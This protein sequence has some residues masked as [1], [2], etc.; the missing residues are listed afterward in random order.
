MPYKADKQITALRL[1]EAEESAEKKA[2]KARSRKYGIGIKPGGNMTKPA[3][4][5]DVSENLFADPVNFRY[6]LSPAMRAINAITRFN[7]TANKAKGGYSDAEWAIMGRRIAKANK[8]KIFKDGQVVDREKEAL[9]GSK[10]SLD[11]FVGKIRDAFEAKFARLP[12]GD[13]RPGCWV[14]DT[15]EDHVVAKMDE[16]FYLIPFEI[17]G[18]E[19]IF[20]GVED[21]T[22][23]IPEKTYVPVTEALRILASKKKK[24]EP[25]G[26]EWEVIIIGPES[27]SD[28]VT[29]GKETYV[30]SKNGR[31]YKASALEAS[32][33]LWDGI[34]V[35]DNHLTDDEM[36]AR[37]GMRSVVH[38][39]V[40]VIV[41][42]AWDA[43]K[44]AVT[45]VLKIVDDNLRAKLLNAEKASV[46]D[47]IG[48][49][50][51]ALGEGI[52]ETI[53]GSTTPVIE[54]ISKALS[55]DVVADPAA[56]GRLSR[57]I[58]GMTG[59]SLP[60]GPRNL[61]SQEVEMDPEEL[62]KLIGDA[63]SASM[64]GFNDR[65]AAIEARL[66]SA[67]DDDPDDDS[68]DDD[69]GSSND[70]QTGDQLPEPVAKAIAAAEARAAALEE[71]MRINECAH[72]L[73]VKLGESGLPESY[74]EIIAEQFRGKVFETADLETA[75]TKHRE[76]L[77]KLSE[78]GKIVLPDGARI[79][80]GSLTELDRIELALLRL[81]AGPTRFTELINKEK[82]EYHGIESIKHFIESEKP[83]L[84]YERRLSEWYYRFTEDYDGLGQ[85]R[86]KRLLEAQVTSSSLSSIV[87]NVV[88]L[89]LAADY[90]VREQW[91][92]PIVRQED[93]D[94]LDQATLVRVFGISTLTA[95]SEGDAYVESAWADE[96]E[97]ASYVKRGNYIGV[98]L[99]T[100]LLDKLN[101]LR[102]LPSRLSNAYYNTIS[103]LV[104]AAFTVN[105]ATGPV[106]ADTGALFNSTAV[107]TAGGHA[108]LGTSA[109]S[110]SSFVAAR[111]AMMK[112]TDQPL[113]VGRR[114]A[115]ANRPR[116]L[117]VPVDLVATAEEIRNSE[118]IPAQSGRATS[119]GQF[120]TVNSVKGQFEI[121]PVPD[122]TDTD[123]WAAIADPAQAPAIF[124]IW[125]RGRR[126]PE[127]FSAEDERSGA[128]F[129]NDELRFKV[130][131]FGFRYSATYDCAPVA[132]FRPLYK[133]NV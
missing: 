53:A 95:M 14:T 115:M 70:T 4:Y 128:M 50:I 68:D 29:E 117:L 28:L 94:T 26:R 81:V 132:D 114:L 89:L 51:D 72:V 37:Q 106:L 101:R 100:F 91:W 77:S 57:M 82:A 18:T 105:T 22:K 124:L 66:A 33:P 52:E 20:A 15:Y 31:L 56:G 125:L 127:L 84:P 85:M 109:L 65:I 45:G 111:T 24:D 6:P 44:K 12:N 103:A 16:E 3:D 23:V 90:S 126:T 46:L 17:D 75:I 64:A 41:K 5:A 129:T 131:Q 93:V 42:P 59:D 40:G 8:G 35:Y 87:K 107:T 96:E 92:D 80:V 21:W 88:N 98:T 30:K 55:V 76:A 104:S 9:H 48:L 121:I 118:M 122:W 71:K 123:N 54:K 47:K 34:K 11:E 69:A 78:S 133:A 74:R 27:D 110:Y 49:S 43:A 108:N 39:W 130:R 79:K 1:K 86:N 112:Q 83:A 13:Y 63:V 116:F 36:A 67:G 32:V 120:Q 61:L 62:K 38:E 102:T 19:V 10:G 60:S 73:G 99:E 7:D 113:G 25:E 2:Q 58:A 119:G 97:T